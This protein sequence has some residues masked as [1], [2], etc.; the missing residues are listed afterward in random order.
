MQAG[1]YC[2]GHSDGISPRN[3]EILR[4][5]PTKAAATV[6]LRREPVY[7]NLALH[8]LQLKGDTFGMDVTVLVV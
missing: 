6:I 3:V 1:I 8:M 7:H 2:I 4:Q 5:V